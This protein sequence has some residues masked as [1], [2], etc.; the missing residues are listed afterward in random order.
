MCIMLSKDEV[1][2]INKLF[3]TGKISNESSLDFALT[4]L[5]KTKDWTTQL[6]YLI[7]TIV[8]DHAFEEGNKRTAAAI[9]IS[10]AEAHKKPFDIYN[11]DK[12]IR[13]LIEKNITDIATIR[14]MIK[15]AIA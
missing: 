1:V 9:M 8:V 6:A 10:Y 2:A 13:D 14:R 11:I 7:R 15:H 12:T 4:T 3:H 5:K